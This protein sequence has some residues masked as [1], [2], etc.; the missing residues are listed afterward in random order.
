M[1][2]SKYRD[3][4]L[5]YHVFVLRLLEEM[6]KQRKHT[7]YQYYPLFC[8]YV[9]QLLRDRLI[10]SVMHL[11]MFLVFFRHAV[12]TQLNLPSPWYSLAEEGRWGWEEDTEG[13]RRCITKWEEEILDQEHKQVRSVLREECDK[14]ETMAV[15]K[16]VRVGRAHHAVLGHR[17]DSTA[18]F[19]HLLIHTFK[20]YWLSTMGYYGKHTTSL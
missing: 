3:N 14:Q 9:L 5:M 8:D 13:W 20:V 1:D 7:Y 11:H 18:P 2:K 12:D 15:I 17:R 19:R 10:F 4:K 16:R 6:I